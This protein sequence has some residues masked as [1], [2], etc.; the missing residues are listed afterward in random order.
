MVLLI[1]LLLQFAVEKLGGIDV[2]IL[3]HIAVTPMAEWHG[4]EEN[5]KDFDMILDVNF[6]AYVHV[7]THA[8]VALEKTAGRLVVV[9]SISGK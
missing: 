2:L 5:Y 4:T 7:A 3:N 1:S 9:S 8:M 6:K